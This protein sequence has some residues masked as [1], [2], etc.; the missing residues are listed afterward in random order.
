[1]LICCSHCRFCSLGHWQRHPTRWTPCSN[2]AEARYLI[3]ATFG[4]KSQHCGTSHAQHCA[5]DLPGGDGLA[6]QQAPHCNGQRR[7]LDKL[8][9]LSENPGCAKSGD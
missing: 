6:Q 9:S 4:P 3:V 8:T 2:G 5:S 1:M 7:H